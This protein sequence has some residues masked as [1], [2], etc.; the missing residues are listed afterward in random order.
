MPEERQRVSLDWIAVAVA[1][2]F[3]VLAAVR[4]L[5]AIPWDSVTIPLIK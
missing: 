2:V 3:A 4:V 5:P 1:A